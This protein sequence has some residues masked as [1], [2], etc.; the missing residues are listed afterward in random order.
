MD[1]TVLILF[2]FILGFAATR[3]GLPPLV[4]YLVAG[5]VL[6]AL[7][8]QGGE[9]MDRVAELGVTLL[10][11]SIGLKLRLRSLTRAEVWGGATLH[12][13]ITAGLFSGVTFGLS[14]TGF[15]IFANLDLKQSILLA[16]AL[17]FSS[18][19][20]AVKVFEERGD[21][22]SLHGRV[23]IGILIMQDIFAVLFITFSS[24]KIPSAWA[25]AVPVALLVLRPLL[26]RIMDH[27]GHRELL[28]LFAVFVA[29]GLG[30]GGFELVGLKGDLGAL[31]LGILVSA[32]PKSGELSKVLLSFKDL[33]LV[34]FFLSIGLSGLPTIQSLG[35]ALILLFILPATVLLYFVL[36]TRFKLRARTSLLASLSL[37][38]YSEFGLIVCTISIRNGWLSGDW[39]II[40]SI[41]LAITFIVASPLNT[42][43]HA[44]YKRYQEV[45]KK[46]ETEGR[47]PDDDPIDPGDAE[48]LIFGMG[49][50]G[51]NTYDE[52][53]ERFGDIVLGLDY[54]SDVV[55]ENQATGREVI[56]DDAAD[57]DF[58]AKIRPDRVRLILLAMQ[59]HAANMYAVE[60]L[61]E[62]NYD[63]LVAATAEFDDQV[64]ELESAGV[65]AAFNIYA[66]AGAGFVKDV[67]ERLNFCRAE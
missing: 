57:S 49:K 39:L 24:G 38:N 51:K 20:F 33:F 6:N 16:F 60:Q 46:F 62:I 3:I 18:T 29:L 27:C 14:L 1:F 31:V 26:F 30:A 63:G 4:G 56:R 10:L 59:N 15:S 22:E 65:H 2:A 41:A 66:E 67:C 35:I 55:K 40:E 61:Q 47:H 45:L 21:M 32:H 42:H 5:F 13:L 11:F 53:R 34:A 54:D 25:F 19:V 44:I 52:M 58:W 28:L 48:I 64:A 37:A 43:A 8:I 12:M 23:S 50:L 36:L 17:S 9:N 7:G